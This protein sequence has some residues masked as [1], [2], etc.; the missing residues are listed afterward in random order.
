MSSRDLL[1]T[2]GSEITQILILAIDDPAAT[3]RVVGEAQY[4]QQ[5]KVYVQQFQKV[6]EDDLTPKADRSSKGWRA[7]LRLPRSTTA[8]H[9]FF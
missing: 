4:F 7:H 1:H 2:A 5:A 6:L 8:L 3:L 9:H